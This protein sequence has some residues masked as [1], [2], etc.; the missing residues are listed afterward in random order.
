VQKEGYKVVARDIQLREGGERFEITL[1]REKAFDIYER[2]MAFLKEG[3]FPEAAEALARATDLNPTFDAA[4]Y[5]R[6][7]A[8]EKVGLFA[9]A[10][11]NYKRAVE[12]DSKRFEYQLALALAL[13]K[14]ERHEEALPRF[15]EAAALRP[16]YPETFL[17]WARTLRKLKQ[18]E[19]ATEQFQ[20]V[21]ALNPRR[22][23]ACDELANVLWDRGERSGDTELTAKA[24]ETRRWCVAIKEGRP[25][26]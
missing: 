18:L 15:K 17:E 20:R 19:E 22:F 5:S 26:P 10:V 11:Q 13:V 12:L 6:G 2:G 8:L 25:K 7:V 14:V 1:E 3:R 24:I 16:E 21:L 9:D 4:F 23:D